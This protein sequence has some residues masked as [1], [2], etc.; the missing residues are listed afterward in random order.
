MILGRDGAALLHAA[1]PAG[2]HPHHRRR[3]AAD[4]PLRVEFT[5][6]NGL[7]AK[8]KVHDCYP[9]VPAGV[10]VESLKGGPKWTEAEVESMRV[11]ANSMCFSTVFFMYDH[12][13]GKE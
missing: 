3:H 9:N 4:G 2:R 7:V 12:L 13:C 11:E 5:A 1:L 6:S 10:L 8:L